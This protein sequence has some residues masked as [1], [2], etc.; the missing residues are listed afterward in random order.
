[1]PSE[2]GAQTQTAVRF[3]R[4]MRLRWVVALGAT[5]SVGLGVFIL[6]GQFTLLAGSQTLLLPYLLTLIF[7][8]PVILTCAERGAVISGSGGIYNLARPSGLV[9]LKYGAGWLL[10]GGYA[11]LIALFGWGVALHLNEIAATLFDGSLN[12]VYL[13]IVILGLAA[14]Y[15]LLGTSW[16][17][18]TRSLFILTGIILLA[19]VSARAIIS[20]A[21]LAI[22]TSL[23]YY[24]SKAFS[25]TA[26]M[27]CLLWGLQFILNIRDQIP[28]PTRTVPQAMLL[29]AGLGAGLG[30]LAGLALI[31][32]GG[33]PVTLTP[34]V[35]TIGQVGLIPPEFLIILYAIS[36]VLISYI[37]L[38]QGVRQALSLVGE[39][40]ADGFF[41]ARIQQYSQKYETP[42]IPVTLLV[43]L[44]ILLI[45][46]APVLW[47]IGLVT[48]TFLWA[49]ALVHLPEAFQ[50]RPNLPENRR[51]KLPFHPLF[52][53]LVIATGLF[54]PFNLIG[55]V[56]LLGL[57]W[58]LLG[59][60]LYLAY[61][62]Q[63]GLVVRRQE[64]V[65]SDKLDTGKLHPDTGYVVLVG[66]ANPDTAPELICAGARLARAKNGVLLA[67]KVLALPEQIPP[68]LKREAAEK[69]LATLEALIQR[70]DIDGLKV[71]PLIRLAPTAVTG[72]SEVISEEGVDLLLLGWAGK[73]TVD[74]TPPGS[75]LDV[76]L[77]R[78]P[79]DV[80]V[81][82]GRFPRLVKRVL[83]PTAGGPYAPAA[84]TLAQVLTT[85][86]DRQ[87]VVETMV[88]SPL[89]PDRERT[90]KTYLERTRSVLENGDTDDTVE[91]RILEVN[92]V[93]TGILGEANRAELLMIGATRE[94]VLDQSFFGGLPVEVAE[95][96]LTPTILVRKKE[97]DQQWWRRLMEITADYLPTLTM[98]RQAE[99]YANMKESAQPSV[100]FFVLI[101]LA[102]SIAILGLLQNSAAVIIG[103]MLVAPLM[104]PILAMAMAMV[105]GNLRLL[106]VAAE[107]T[108]KGIV[109]AIVVGITVTII[110]PIDS[111]TN[112]IMARTAPNLLDLLVAL[113]SGAAA[114]YAIGRKEVAAALPGVAIAAALVPPLCVVGYGIGTSDLSIATGSLL[115][116]TTN[117]IAIVLAGALVFLALGFQP[118]R[119]ERGELLRGLK[120]TVALLVPITLL[121]AGTTIASTIEANRRARVERIFRNEIVA[122]SAEVG[123]L[124]IQRDW[125]NDKFI[126]EATIIDNPDQRLTSGQLAVLEEELVEAVGGPVTLKTTTITG[127]R[128]EYER[129]L[130]RIRQLETFFA[131]E[132]TRREA[133][134]IQ[135]TVDQ[136]SDGFT[137]VASV[138]ALGEEITERDMAEV[139]A[140]LSQQMDAPVIIRT[141]IISGTQIRIEPTP[142]M[143]A[144][145]QP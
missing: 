104:S 29:T 92:N 56:W 4:V 22:E 84:L 117:L 123:E 80:A 66:L 50:A 40:V 46:I 43:L 140:E 118:P 72:L 78:A 142:T 14:L 61:A 125:R 116:F 82:R 33:S 13:T 83:V 2:A 44:S 137:I 53:W 114:G 74:D 11:G 23:L 119:A 60:F 71:R 73:E 99:V 85:S 39:M 87:I 59:S 68:H 62:R 54:L 110:S 28:R 7:G 134:V 115:L 65:I 95:A 105:Q 96:T 8:L 90:A 70:A 141:T 52:P 100:D 42:I 35:A 10:L 6:L 55:R 20:P 5:V 143:T 67:L 103:A 138:I 30:A 58:V 16:S 139:Q 112:E 15:N 126:I 98:A 136:Q 63:A 3:S 75:T 106:L 107:A 111:P 47:V 45:S 1:M 131:G 77:K 94:G 113:A 76:L 109:L 101:T 122:R 130:Q 93:K 135:L 108:A 32:Y 88:D 132:M 37:G 81:L 27:F 144:T 120:V 38:N 97:G 24:R 26:L 12:L 21:T 121:L 124:T 25:V 145:P 36:G 48:L 17:W 31:S 49:T 133:Q 9:W 128:S 41:P 18:P 127:V 34:L 89:S 102:A 69:E 79:C 129:E 19:F 91:E 64:T 86:E 51:L 57:S